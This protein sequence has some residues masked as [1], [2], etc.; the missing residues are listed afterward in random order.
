MHSRL[1]LI[2]TNKSIS[3]IG[4][5]CNFPNTSHFIKLFKKQYGQ[6][7]ATYRTCQVGHP[8]ARAVQPAVYDTEYRQAL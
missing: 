3:E 2:S 5:E 1:L 7:P 4:M 6:T 8:A